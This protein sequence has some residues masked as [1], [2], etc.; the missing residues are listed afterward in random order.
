MLLAIGLYLVR[1]RRRRISLPRPAFL[2][3]DAAI[4]FTILVNLFLLVMPW[5]P[6]PGGKGDVSFW[7]ATYVVTGIG[8][9]LGCGV[10]YW[11][12]IWALPKLGG[13]R[14]RQAVVVLDHGAQSHKLVKVP[15]AELAQW[16]ETHD[17]IGRRVGDAFEGS[18]EDIG[19]HST[20]TPEKSS[21]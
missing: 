19:I 2:T 9:I 7:Y 15:V 12:W 4:V 17:A 5:Y 3:W 16:D 10:Y 20:T 11:L 1:A 21:V 18:R 6:P 8:I 13:Y 14:V